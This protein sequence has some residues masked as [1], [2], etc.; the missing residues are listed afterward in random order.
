MKNVLK[1]VARES[2]VDRLA[3]E[4]R[5]SINSGDYTIGERLPTIMEMARRFG[6]GHPTVREALKKLEATGVL[7]I[8]HGSGVYVT[9]T[10]DVLVMASDYSGKV[11][12][13]LLLDLIQARAPIE[14]QSAALASRNGTDEHFAEMRR[15]LTTAGENLDNDSVLNSVNM[16]FH[17]QIASA[18][19][20]A[21][22]AQLLDVMQTLFTDEQRLILGIFGSRKQDHQEHLSIFAA[23]EQRQEQLATERMRQHLDG[24]AAAIERWDPQHHPVS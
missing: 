13:K 14:A 11:T 8:R 24:V 3:G 23:L 20:N 17:R 19:G 10:Q 12:K 16:A 6:V 2:L 18:S 5:G 1:P 7:E 4:I 22:I 9:R 15:L 21:V